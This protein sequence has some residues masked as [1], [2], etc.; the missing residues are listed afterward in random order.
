MKITPAE[1]ALTVAKLDKINARAAKRGW[2]GRVTL[3]ATPTTITRTVGGITID[4]V[5]LGGLTIEEEAFEV[6]LG[7]DAPSYNGWSFLATLDWDEHAGLVTRCA[8]GVE[9]V[10]DRDALVAGWCDHCRT[11]RTRKATYLVRNEE[12]GVQLQV[13]SSCIKDFLGWTG[14]VCFIYD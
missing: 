13:G 9:V 6:E 4:G 11:T 14:S 2:T 10:V 1:L 7:G 12:T 8:P 5:N 3:E